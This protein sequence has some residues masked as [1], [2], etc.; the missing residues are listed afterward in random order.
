MKTSRSRASPSRVAS[1]RRSRLTASLRSSAAIALKI[2]I[3][4]RRRRTATRIWCTAS[5][6]RVSRSTGS[7]ARRCCRQE[8]PMTWKLL[9]ALVPG[10]S[11]GSFAL[12]AFLGRLPARPA[13]LSS[14]SRPSSARRRAGRSV[15]RRQNSVSAFRSLPKSRCHKQAP[16]LTW[17]RRLFEEAHQRL[18]VLRVRDRLLGHLGA[19]RVA[20][21]A[22][23]EQLCDRLRAPY[24]VHAL[25]RLGEIIAWG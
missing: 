11:G 23:L 15:I 9:P 22:D 19:G 24:D 21:R 12:T 25:Q 7:L 5:G 6:S 10:S 13:S 18:A 17:L 2:E 1:Q 4:A 3:A 8:K 16:A 20:R 14:A